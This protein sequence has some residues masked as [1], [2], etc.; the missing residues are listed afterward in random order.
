MKSKLVLAGAMVALAVSSAPASAEHFVPHLTY[1][2]GPFAANGALIANGFAD[3]MTMINERDGGVGGVKVKVEECETGYNAQKGVECYESTKGRGA[4]VS[5]PNSTGITLQLMQKAPI[6]QI[7]LLTPGYGL[8]AGADGEKFP[9]A[10][11]FPATYWGQ[12]SAILSWI[13]EQEGGDLSALKGKK[14]GLIY[15]DVGYG[16]EPIPLMDSLAEKYGFTT[17]K[18]PVGVEM[19]NQS[20]HWLTVRKEKPDWM[21]MWGWGAMNSTAIKAAAKIRY[22]M[23]KFIGNWWSSSHVDVKG[24]GKAAKGYRGATFSSNGTS[25]PALQDIQKL[26]SRPR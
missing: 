24:S 25:F 6:D 18:I 14:I 1:R 20:S 10:F 2:T 12:M 22:P 19:Q 13:G 23:D 5:L 17:L 8:S 3:Y 16:R 9:W 11:N 26:V 4:L 7:P 21:I 15:L